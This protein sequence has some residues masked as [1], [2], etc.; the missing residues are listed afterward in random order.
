[1]KK[2]GCYQIE[3][4]LESGN[5]EVL[6]D[7]RKG[8]TVENAIS[9]AR[10]VKKHGIAPRVNFLLGFPTETEQALNDTINAMKRIDGRFGYS[11]FTPYP[12]SEAYEFC[13]KNGLISSD[14]DASLY[15][16]QSPENC[17]CAN[18]SK[19][20]F[21]AIAMEIERYVDRRETIEDFKQLLFHGAIDRLLNSGAFRNVESFNNLIRN[22]ILELRLV[23]KGLI[24]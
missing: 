4:G 24:S 23:L 6:R 7:M 3:M 13:E 5:N 21:R 1:M 16:H 17:F 19:E 10:I 18:I 2:A 11:I 9:A 22:T 14:S 12:G 20:R 8:I 15:N